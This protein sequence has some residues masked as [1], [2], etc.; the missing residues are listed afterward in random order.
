MMK[1]H[2][3]CLEEKLKDAGDTIECPNRACKKM[4]RTKDL[5]ILLER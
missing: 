4:Q 5:K 3:K 2:V 1:Y